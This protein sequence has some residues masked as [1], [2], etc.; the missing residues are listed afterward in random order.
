LIT[1]NTPNASVTAPV[2]LPYFTGDRIGFTC[3]DRSLRLFLVPGV[4][5]EF[6]RVSL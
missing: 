3:E 1:V 5:I 6:D 4:S 2:D